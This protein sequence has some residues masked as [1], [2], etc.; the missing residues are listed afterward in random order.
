MSTLET[1]ALYCTHR[2]RAFGQAFTVSSL[3]AQR[4]IQ[5]FRAA[6]A[7]TASTAR[8][9]HAQ[10]RIEQIVFLRLLHTQVIREPSPGRYFLDQHRQDQIEFQVKPER[11]GVD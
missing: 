7:L 8:P 3:P 2:V 5:Q 9:L 11:V 1:F 6:G 10:S 4:I